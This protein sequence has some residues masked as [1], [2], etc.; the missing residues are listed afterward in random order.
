MVTCCAPS[1]DDAVMDADT[2]TRQ[3]CRRST[4]R[5]ACA[6]AYVIA[7]VIAVQ[8][9]AVVSG[10]LEFLIEPKLY[11]FACIRRKA[12]HVLGHETFISC[13]YIHVSIA[14]YAPLVK[15]VCVC[16]CVG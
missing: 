14:E 11:L 1:S 15:S 8:V 16:M 9:L 2:C 3:C 12:H 10:R 13:Q 5:S 7:A 4:T 6:D